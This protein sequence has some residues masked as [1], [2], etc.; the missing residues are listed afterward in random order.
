MQFPAGGAALM[1]AE[2]RVISGDLRVVAYASVIDNHSGDPIYVA[3]S[4]PRVGTFA[5]PVISQPGVNTFWRS[6]VFIT[7]PAGS[8]GSFDLT[9]VDAVTGERITKHGNVAARQAIRLDDVVGNYFGRPGGFGTIRADLAGNLIATSRTF[10]SSPLG[11]FGQFIPFGAGDPAVNTRELLHIERSSA[12]RTNLG[13]INTG[14]SDQ[15][16][17]FTLYDSAGRVLG[18]TDRG[19]APLRMIQF[20]LDQLSSSPLTGGRVEVQVIGGSGTAVAWASVIDNI[21]GDPI[22]VPA[23]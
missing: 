17:R 20:P 3:A 12:F 14:D 21:T 1:T 19:I 22:F 7:A 4:A 11:T 15:V 18:S 16:V 23:Q 2:L 6:D 10:T 9:Y 5:A 8:S 13:A